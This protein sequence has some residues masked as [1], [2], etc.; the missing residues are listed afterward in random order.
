VSYEQEYS[1]TLGTERGMECGPNHVKVSTEVFIVRLLSSCE[2]ESEVVDI[3]FRT[4]VSY[5][6]VE[7]RDAMKFVVHYFVMNSFCLLMLVFVENVAVMMG[8]LKC[9]KRAI[10]LGLVM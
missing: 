8:C 4:V 2:C 6:S 10:V 3:S 5:L 1:S 7:R 9:C